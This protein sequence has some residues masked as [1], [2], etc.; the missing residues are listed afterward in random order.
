ML[1]CLVIFHQLLKLLENPVN[2]LEK[3]NLAVYK[4]LKLMVA[5]HIHLFFFS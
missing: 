3:E 2:D 5:D 1:L 4:T